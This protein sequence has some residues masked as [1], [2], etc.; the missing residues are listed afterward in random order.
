MARIPIAL[1]PLNM[2]KMNVHP[3]TEIFPMMQEDELAELADDIKANGLINPIVVDA[4]G[5]LIDGRNRLEACR[6]VGVQPIFQTLDGIDPVAFILSSNDKRRHMS[7]GQR[8]MIA[9]KVRLLL[10]NKST[11]NAAAEIGVA[12]AY[13]AKA[14]IVLEFAPDLADQVIAGNKSLNEAYTEAQK[15]KEDSQTDESRIAR[16]R[17]EAPDL[18]DQIAEEKLTI[19]E[20][21]GALNARDAERCEQ[22]IQEREAK[23]RATRLFAATVALF[24]PRM[25]NADQAASD[26][27]EMIDPK[28]SE[29]NLSIERIRQAFSVFKTIV[30]NWKE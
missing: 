22:E 30:S 8:A 1:I 21:I 20:A 11:T 18:A 23:T 28:L 10:N 15:R 3:I 5:I 13:V 14:S 24:D 12:Q 4:N 29:E 6:R 19:T 27:L 7:K 17:K 16:L 26:L 9:A 25:M 2:S